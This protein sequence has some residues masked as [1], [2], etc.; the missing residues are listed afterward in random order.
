MQT[1]RSNSFQ[2]RP[3]LS[4]VA[5]HAAIR[6]RYYDDLGRQGAI[7]RGQKNQ[8]RARL[9]YDILCNIVYIGARRGHSFP[10]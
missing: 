10:V 7:S 5:L 3:C 8:K 6:P 9:I 1:W 2:R 4:R